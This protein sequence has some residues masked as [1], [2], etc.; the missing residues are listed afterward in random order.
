MPF[1]V[2]FCYYRCHNV[3]KP[4][5]FALPFDAMPP[6]VCPACNAVV[7]RT[8]QIKSL[9]AVQIKAEPQRPYFPPSQA[10]PKR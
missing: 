3:V 7:G 10:Q 8:A 6:G 4:H 9:E 5:G 2:K 1:P